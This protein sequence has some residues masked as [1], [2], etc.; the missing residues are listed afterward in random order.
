MRTVERST[1]QPNCSVQ[2]Y[3]CSIYKENLPGVSITIIAMSDKKMGAEGKNSLFGSEMTDLDKAFDGY[4]SSSEQSGGTGETASKLS[5]QK[6]KPAKRSNS[7]KKGR[8]KKPDGMPR[9]PPSGY[10]LFFKEQREIIIQERTDELQITTKGKRKKAK[11]SF[12]ELAKV[13]G[14]R[15]KS[16]DPAEHERFKNM[17][18]EY[19]RRYKVEMD[20]Y[21]RSTDDELKRSG[22]AR[23]MSMPTTH[24]VSSTPPPRRNTAS[25]PSLQQIDHSVIDRVQPTPMFSTALAG[26]NEFA[27]RHHSQYAESTPNAPS[28]HRTAQPDLVQLVYFDHRGS[29]N[30]SNFQGIPPPQVYYGSEWDQCSTNQQQCGVYPPSGNPIMSHHMLSSHHQGQQQQKF[31]EEFNRQRYGPLPAFATSCTFDTSPQQ[32]QPSGAAAAPSSEPSLVNLL[33]ANDFFGPDDT[34]NDMSWM[35]PRPI[36][37][38]VA[39]APHTI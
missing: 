19:A 7:Y 11:I 29:S 22:E 14:A 13:I 9:R 26:M 37:P 32:Q 24:V 36:A 3:D 23:P 10:N 33:N 27:L 18:D 39:K 38:G 5:S 2:D 4:L 30:S 16:I 8:M 35:D 28:N 6:K 25:F 34:P 12:E 15:W 17:G 20:T 31:L 21:L 1:I